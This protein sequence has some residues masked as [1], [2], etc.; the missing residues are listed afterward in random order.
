MVGTLMSLGHHPGEPL[1]QEN[2]NDSG[3]KQE[4]LEK[5]AAGRHSPGQPAAGAHMCPCGRPHKLP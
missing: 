1:R 4:R 3:D 2:Y 5:Q